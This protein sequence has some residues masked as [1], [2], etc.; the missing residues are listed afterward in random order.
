VPIGI[1]QVLE[2]ISS[3]EVDDYTEAR[4]SNVKFLK[5]GGT[6][7]FTK[8]NWAKELIREIAGERTSA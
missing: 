2:A 5:E 3:G 7:N 6:E 4:Y 1:T 8:S